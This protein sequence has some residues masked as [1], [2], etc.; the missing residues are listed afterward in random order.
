VTTA[1]YGQVI[2][3]NYTGQGTDITNNPSSQSGLDC[4]DPLMA[5]STLCRGTTSGY[6]QFGGGGGGGMQP[7]GGQLPGAGQGQMTTYT[8][9][10]GQLVRRERSQMIPLLPEPLTEFQKFT[11]A[12]TGMLLPIFGASL[13]QSVPST[14]APL[15][16]TPVPPDYVIGPDDEVRIRVW[17]QVNF[18]ANLLVDRSGTIYVPQ[19]G[20]V[21]V[22]GTKFSDLDQTIRRAVSKIYRNFEMTVELGQIRAI[23]IY[24]T[25]EARRPGMYT[26]S[27]LSTLVDALFASGGPS[28]QG[29]MRQIEVRRGGAVVTTFDLYRL[30]IAGDKSKDTKLLPGDVIYVAP[31]GPQAAVLGSV[32]RPAIYE[33]LPGETVGNVLKYA[34]NASSLATDVRA[35]LDRNM[36]HSGRQAMEVRL[37]TA[38]LAFPMKDG[39]ILRVISIVSKYQN[40]V[41]LRGNVANPGRFAWHE[42]MKLSDLIPDKESLITRDY[43]W[44]RGRLG[45]PSPEFEPV[46]AFSTLHQPM[47][48]VDLP[49][50]QSLQRRRTAQ[51]ALTGAQGQGQNA[52]QTPGQGMNQAP[53]QNPDLN[54]PDYYWNTTDEGSSPYEALNPANNLGVPGQGAANQ[55]PGTGTTG[56]QPSGPRGSESALAE[57]EIQTP[58]QINP[59]AT[60]RTV[61]RLSAPEIDWSYGVIERMD[62]GTLKT[63]LIPFDLG[64]LVLQ[65]DSS[66]DLEL[67]A[68]DMVSIFSQSDIHVPIAE[69]T[70]LVRLEGEVVH[71]GTY[72][73]HPGDTLRTL[74]ERAGGLTPNA[75]LFG[76][77]FTRESTRVLQQRRMDEAVQRM[78]LQMQRGAL[79]LASS[80]TSSPQDVAAAGAAQA[81]SKDLV[82]QLQQIRATGRIVFGFR[83]ESKS[84]DEIPDV[85][86][87]NGDSFLIP[88]VPSTVNAVGAVF[89]QNSFLFQ[90]D[91]RVE[92]YLALAGGPNSDADKKHMFLVK[93]NGAVIAKE[94]VKSAWGNDFDR[95]KLNPG[96]TIVVPDKSIKAS[97]LRSFMYLST[98]FSQLMYGIAATTVVF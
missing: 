66:Q 95:L 57:P 98:F 91:A 55:Q 16:S 76:S 42:G 86:L 21:Q 26:V 24:V 81:S 4:T 60:R 72:S 75:Y 79:S 11:S 73:A 74:V 40:T 93:A 59:Q 71:A 82:T 8:D 65:H 13:F 89:N 77:V 48:P 64:K 62:P 34:G 56:Q 9:D 92:S 63:T 94:S 96:D 5:A 15:D 54:M 37:D 47:N 27:S 7:F 69:Q 44:K 83:P 52:N 35:S 46:P 19:V 78:V 67:Q 61:V 39:D 25:G 36:E 58:Q 84:V 32:R 51:Q 28:V 43:W 20:A 14:F 33:L 1:A 17:G 31:V 45:L 6:S 10:R 38:G 3:P 29:S 2:N 18:N 68:G 70:S 22:A 87:E 53:L 41:T 97:P 90:P 30:L 80:G 50:E 23:Q 85:P 88:P 12:T 49:L